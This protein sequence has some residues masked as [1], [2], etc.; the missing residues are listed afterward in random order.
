M[1]CVFR[2]SRHRLRR[3]RAAAAACLLL[4]GCG[5]VVDHLSYDSDGVA[6]DVLA[7]VDHNTAWARSRESD[8]VLYRIELRADRP[9]AAAPAY[10]LYS[11]Y[12]PKANSFMTATSDPTVPWDGAEP[13][14]WPLD[15]IPP[16]PLPAVAMDFREAWRK[17]QEAGLTNVTTATLEVHRR[18][19]LALVVWSI[20]GQLPKA[21]EGG[22]YFD[23]LSKERLYRTALI[24]PPT[25]PLLI[26]KS[27]Y[28]YR[29]AFR[30]RFNGPNTC[31]GSAIAIPAAKPVVCFDVETRLYQSPRDGPSFMR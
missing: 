18:F 15:L 28:E 29:R 4:V 11:F 31:T 21:G 17:A 26:E 19:G 2:L 6:K 27:L 30:G 3:P 23:A 16:M 8:A 12:S 20:L 25:D 14:Y 9:G 7:L 1:S 22:V 10:A 24:T 13:Q 5:G